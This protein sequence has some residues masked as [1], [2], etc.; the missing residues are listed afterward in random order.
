MSKNKKSDSIDKEKRLS[1]T[2]KEANV[3]V[4]NKEPKHVQGHR[5]TVTRV[6]E[7]EY[8][9]PECG[10]TFDNKD[11]AEEHLHSQHGE[12][13]RTVHRELHGKDTNQQHKE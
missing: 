8:M 12:H 9:C 4:M 5:T 1:E 7:G 10:Q 13:L 11:R 3:D 2:R 6:K